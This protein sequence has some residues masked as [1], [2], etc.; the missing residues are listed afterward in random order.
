MCTL[1]LSGTTC[2]LIPYPQDPLRLLRLGYDRNSKKY[3]CK[4]RLMT[5]AFFIA[6]LVW[7]LLI[8]P[9]GIKKSEIH[10][11]EGGRY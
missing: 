6:L 1:A 11:A 3:R 5:P 4:Q 2:G 7:A 10:A 9:T 8:T